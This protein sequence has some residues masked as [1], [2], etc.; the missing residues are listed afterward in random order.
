MAGHGL[1]CVR[2]YSTAQRRYGNIDR[3]A[4]RSNQPFAPS[5]TNQFEPRTRTYYHDSRATSIGTVV[6]LQRSTTNTVKNAGG[7][8]L[9][10]RK[11][12]RS[13]DLFASSCDH[14]LA[15]AE[16]SSERNVHSFSGMHCFACIYILY[17]IVL[18]HVNIQYTRST[19]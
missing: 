17:M 16:R 14:R 2:L 13:L 4:R 11:P 12:R 7:T 5:I 6:E 9:K 15:I 10:S 18:G 19:V 1:H 8:L 3:P